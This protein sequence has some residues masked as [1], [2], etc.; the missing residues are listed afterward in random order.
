MKSTI[1]ID[2]ELDQ[3]KMP[4]TIKW[5]AT[6]SEANTLQDARAFMLSIWD[7]QERSALRIDLWTKQMMVDEMN[8][9]FYQTFMTMADTYGRSVPNTELVNDIKKFASTFYDKAQ[10]TLADSVNKNKQE[11]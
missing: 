10:K 1:Q 11:F 9:F 8:D 4:E 2:V 5:M 7:A 6:A 3:Q